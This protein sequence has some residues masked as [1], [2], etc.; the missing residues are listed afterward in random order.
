MRSSDAFPPMPVAIQ[1]TYNTINHLF[2]L[3]KKN[4][5]GI[6]YG[7]TWAIATLKD[8]QKIYLDVF[9]FDKFSMPIACALPQ[10]SEDILFVKGDKSVFILDWKKK[11]LIASFKDVS[12]T[13][14][15]GL[16]KTKVIDYG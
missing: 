16:D 4:S 9:P 6:V 8:N 2:P 3:L 7:E 11:E 13:L 15:V 5:V 12:K 14:D 1:V 10:Y